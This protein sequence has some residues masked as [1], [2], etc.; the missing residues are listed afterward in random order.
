MPLRLSLV[1]ACALIDPDGRVQRAV[2]APL[3]GR[4]LEAGEPP[5][6]VRAAARCSGGTA[7]ELPVDGD[8]AD[9]LT[10]R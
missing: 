9:E 3:G 8:E 5:A 4:T 10:L 6:R 1:I 7:H 2:E